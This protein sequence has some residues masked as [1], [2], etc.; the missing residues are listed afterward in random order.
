MVSAA[1]KK[2]AS[3][4][5]RDPHDWYVE[6][7]WTVELLAD[8]VRFQGGIHDPCCGKGTIPQVFRQRGQGASGNDIMYR[9]WGRMDT[10]LDFREDHREYFNVVSNPPYGLAETFVW[11]YLDRVTGKI[12]I[13][14]RLDFL[15]SQ[16]RNP[17][18]TRRPPALVLILSRRPSMPP[19]WQGQVKGEGGQHDYCWIVWG[20]D[21]PGVPQIEWA[22]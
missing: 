4:Y 15:A 12:A 13:I 3:G 9:G 21:Y 16:G 20:Q 8:R 19:G 11:H 17:L 1:P 2:K 22:M 10:E 18:F 7:A 6:P 14:T 5:Q